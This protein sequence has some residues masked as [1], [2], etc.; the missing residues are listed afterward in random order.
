MAS[1]R[2]TTYIIIFNLLMGLLLFLS[3]QIILLNLV[4]YKAVNVGV[5]IE[6][7][8]SFSPNGYPP[9]TAMLPPIPNY[10]LMIFII[11]VIVNLVF[12]YK[13]RTK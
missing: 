2:L 11:M 5:S 6:Y 3:S 13:I 7:D 12:Y 9:P 10:P 4:G 8:Y 1:N